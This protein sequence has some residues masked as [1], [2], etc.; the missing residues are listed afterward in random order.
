MKRQNTLLSMSFVTKK[1]TTNLTSK[2]EPEI[3]VKD[4]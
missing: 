2:N 4:E 3:V 1:N